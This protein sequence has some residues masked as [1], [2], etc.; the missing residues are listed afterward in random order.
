[1]RQLVIGSLDAIKIG[2][3]MALVLNTTGYLP[4]GNNQ[5]QA[6]AVYGYCDSLGPCPATCPKTVLGGSYTCTPAA[7]AAWPGDCTGG[8]RSRPDI[9]L[10][11][12]AII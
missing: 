6:Y 1:M 11:R 4:L 12:N 3:I 7:G 10:F 9:G 2:L 5:S 8:N